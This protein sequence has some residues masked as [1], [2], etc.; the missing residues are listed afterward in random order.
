MSL[1]AWRLFIAHVW[2]STWGENRCRSYSQVKPMPPCSSVQMRVARSQRCA[3]ASAAWRAAASGIWSHAC[4]AY[5][6][7]DS[8]GSTLV[9]MSASWCFTP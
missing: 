5:H 7:S 1:V 8:A 2:R 4:A 3:F 6:H 9:T